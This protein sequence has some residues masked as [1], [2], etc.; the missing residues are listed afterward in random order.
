[1]LVVAPSS[2]PT[3]LITAPRG[4]PD[5]ESPPATH[6]SATSRSPATFGQGDR[7][8]R[9]HGRRR[10]WLSPQR[11]QPH[12]Q[13]HRRRQHVDQHLHRPRFPGPGVTAVGYF[14]CMF[15]DGGGYWRHEGWGEPAAFNDVVHLVYA[16]HGAGA[17]AGDVYYIRSTDSGVTFSAPFKLNTDATTRPQWQPNISVSPTGTLFATWYD[18]RESANCT[19][20]NPAVP[21]YRMWSRKSNDNGATWLPDDTFSDVVSPLPGQSDPGIQ[22]DLCGR[23]RLRLRGDHQAPHFMDGRARGHRRRISAGCLHRQGAGRFRRDQHGSSCAQHHLHSAD[24]LHG[25]PD[26]PGGSGNR[27]GHRFHR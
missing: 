27:P 1:M 6:S 10:R 11:Q 16:Q 8:H 22:A 23:L 24:G 7:V 2:S 20:G 21:C 25:Q 4:Q 26:R 12:L 18:A 3:P 13:V 19:E 17:D 9:R 5:N 15:T 14:A